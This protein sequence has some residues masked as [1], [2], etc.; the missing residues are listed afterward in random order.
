M[1]EV[2]YEKLFKAIFTAYKIALTWY[3][4]F[5]GR[6]NLNTTHNATFFFMKCAIQIVCKCFVY[7]SSIFCNTPTPRISCYKE[8]VFAM[9]VV[10]IKI[11]NFTQIQ[12]PFVFSVLFLSLLSI[13]EPVFSLKLKLSVCFWPSPPP[14]MW[15]LSH[16]DSWKPLFFLTC[17][18]EGRL[19]SQRSSVWLISTLLRGNISQG[20]WTVS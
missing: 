15:R 12:F 1:F 6:L 17:I 5:C 9:R 18:I 2:V 3:F 13:F 4:H 20:P 11:F 14:R 16:T 10:I 7:F 8:C 19:I